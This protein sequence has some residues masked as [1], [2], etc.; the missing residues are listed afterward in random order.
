[1]DDTLSRRSAVRWLRTFM[2]Y[3]LIGSRIRVLEGASGSVKSFGSRVGGSL[4][5]SSFQWQAYFR[6][7]AVIRLLA[8]RLSVHGLGVLGIGFRDPCAGA[9][10]LCG[11]STACICSRLPMSLYI[12]QK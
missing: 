3:G 11:E 4:V 10:V 9:R 5:I 1:M 2:L 12:F 6:P 8:D 7:L